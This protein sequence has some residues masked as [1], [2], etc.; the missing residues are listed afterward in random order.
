[1][2]TNIEK[3]LIKE[4]EHLDRIFMSVSNNN[5]KYYKMAFFKKAYEYINF[6]KGYDK[7]R[8]KLIITFMTYV[9]RTYKKSFQ[10]YI[11]IMNKKLLTE[12]VDIYTIDYISDKYNIDIYI[13]KDDTKD[14]M[15]LYNLKHRKSLILYYRDNNHFDSIG[16]YESDNKIIMKMPNNK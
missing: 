7:I 5:V 3:T 6:V 4:L 9:K 2:E 10:D 13:I 11:N 14:L 8:E 12:F 16:M 1:M 15:K